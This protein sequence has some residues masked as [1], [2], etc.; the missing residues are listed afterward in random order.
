MLSALIYARVSTPGQAEDGLGLEAQLEACRQVAERYEFTVAPEHIITEQGS[1]AFLEREGLDRAR[2]IVRSKRVSALIVYDTDRLS[3]EEIGTVIVLSEAQ[4]AGVTI[5][6]RS[7]PVDTTRE[8]NLISYVRSYAAALEKDKIRQRTMDGKRQAAKQGVL[9]VGTGSGLFGYDYTRRDKAGKRPQSR[10]INDGEAQVVRR[11]FGMALEGLGLSTI[12][13]ILNKDS[14]PSKQGKSWHPRTVYSVLSNPSYMGVTRYGAESTKL[15]A[16]GH[17]ERRKRDESD[18][19]MIPG[20]TP[21]IVDASTFERV[22]RHL[23]RPRRS[24]HAH[25]PYML[26]GLLTCADCGTSLTGQKMRGQWRYYVCRATSPTSIRPRLCNAKRTRTE[27]LDE[28]VWKAVSKAVGSSEFIYNRLLALQ[29]AP[30][31]GDSE[32][33]A[34]AIKSRIK[35]LALEERNLVAALRTAPSAAEG[36]TGELEKIASEKKS[37]ERQIKALS[38]ASHNG[39]VAV[40]MEAVKAFCGAVKPFLKAMDVETRRELLSLLGFEAVVKDTGEVEASIAAPQA[41]NVFTT[42]RT[43]ALSRGRSP[44]CLRV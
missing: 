1:G 41:Q 39:H 18:V 36:I 26:S 8:G 16:G 12:A 44:R 14:I 34:S 20:F 43:W 40:T 33:M 22:Q 37:L 19:A 28:R 32:A 29:D 5:Y 31:E 38:E 4:Q 23:A 11:M 30:V 10:A 25:A 17:R 27:S 3:R 7:G 42:G 6:T 13:T 21:A 15:L 9:P 2:A 35:T 24:G